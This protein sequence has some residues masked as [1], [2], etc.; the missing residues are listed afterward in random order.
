MSRE[1][2]L[3]RAARDAGPIRPGAIVVTVPMTVETVDN[4]T[5][6]CA[7]LSGGALHRLPFLVTDLLPALIELEPSPIA[8]RRARLEDLDALRALQRVCF[9]AELHDDD[10]AIRG[11]ITSDL[12]LVAETNGQIVGAA[13]ATTR[14]EL[15]GGS[16]LHLYAVEVHP[17]H[18]RRGL[19]KALV[20][21]LFQE[22]PPS[23]LVMSAHPV[24]PEGWRLVRALYPRLVPISS[25]SAQE[26]HLRHYSALLRES[27]TDEGEVQLAIWKVKLEDAA[28]GAGRCPSCCR[29][30][31]RRVDPR[32]DGHNATPGGVWI[33]YRCSCGYLMDR[34]EVPDGRA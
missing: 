5:A 23:W 26:E 28:L 21:C 32:Q 16:P 29:P 6:W 11:C 14:A 8:F 31:A 7:W 25:R 9:E 4:G 19:A 24:T 30:V 27:G 3:R 18:R 22:L 33:N 17:E 34:A 10:D 13:I 12:F 20:R 2:I 15:A 1:A